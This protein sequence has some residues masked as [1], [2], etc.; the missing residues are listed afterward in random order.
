MRWFKT[1]I[2]VVFFVALRDLSRLDPALIEALVSV[3][4]SITSLIFNFSQKLSKI[5]ANRR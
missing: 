4:K 3:A 5:V 2:F 1:V